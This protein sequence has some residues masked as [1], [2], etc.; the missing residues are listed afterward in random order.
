MLEGSII[1][2]PQETVICQSAPKKLCL[3]YFYQIINLTQSC[4]ARKEKASLRLC[5]R[6]FWFFLV[7]G[8]KV[9]AGG[10]S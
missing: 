7:R 8:R 2:P 6:L 5:V 1:D 9:S 3:C 4:K 10:V